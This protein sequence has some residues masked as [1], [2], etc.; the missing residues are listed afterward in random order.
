MT[1][2][3]NCQN[4]KARDIRI[5]ILVYCINFEA[6]LKGCFEDFFQQTARR[7]L[8]RNLTELVGRIMSA[9]NIAK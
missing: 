6:Q 9:D 5:K 3:E 7:H 2:K 8:Q 1:R 4:R